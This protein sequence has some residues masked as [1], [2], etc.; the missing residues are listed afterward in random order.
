MECSPKKYVYIFQTKAVFSFFEGLKI[1]SVA[2]TITYLPSDVS[3]KLQSSMTT[4][5][6]KLSTREGRMLANG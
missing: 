4:F 3:S 2:I 6:H 1:Y 5:H